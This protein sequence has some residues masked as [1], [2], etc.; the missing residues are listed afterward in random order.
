MFL[1][2]M[3]PRGQSV[4]ILPV[5]SGE[6]PDPAGGLLGGVPPAS[7]L[8][9]LSMKY[10]TSARPGQEAKAAA[11][12]STGKGDAGGVSYGAYQLSSTYK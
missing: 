5:P 8:G 9:N 6:A 3:R 7:R 4:G 10:E 2:R 12:V 11:R 1:E